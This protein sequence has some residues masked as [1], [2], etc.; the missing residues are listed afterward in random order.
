MKP[1]ENKELIKGEIADYYY[2]AE[3]ILY[4]YS[5]STKRTVKNISENIG[6][7]CTTTFS[8]RD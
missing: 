5:K 1:S 8:K 4:S 7:S 3:G 2:S 6:G